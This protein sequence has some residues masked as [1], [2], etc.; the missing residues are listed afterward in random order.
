[1]TEKEITEK[2]QEAKRAY[3]REWYAKTKTNAENATGAIG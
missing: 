3:Q 2:V 1:M